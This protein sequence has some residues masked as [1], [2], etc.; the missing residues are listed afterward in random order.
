[1]RKNKSRKSN[2]SLITAPTE[3]IDKGV[4]TQRFHLTPVRMPIIKTQ[5]I[6]IVIRMG[7]I[8]TVE[9]NINLCSYY[10]N[11]HQ[12]IKTRTTI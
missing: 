3:R 4:G 10:G 2:T 5:T 7:V 8:D 12:K 1:V 9:G 6:K 11:W